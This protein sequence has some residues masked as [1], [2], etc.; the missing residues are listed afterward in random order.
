MFVVVIMELQREL[1]DKNK[2]KEG[3]GFDPQRNLVLG[4]RSA[5]S[6][7]LLIKI[8]TKK[9]KKFKIRY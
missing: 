5:V 4:G 8:R 1:R 2:S 7:S 6:A 9:C 3:P